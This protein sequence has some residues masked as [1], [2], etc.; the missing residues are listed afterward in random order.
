M[1]DAVKVHTRV[2]SQR[3][4]RAD[5]HQPWYTT[6]NTKATDI[7]TLVAQSQTSRHCMNSLALGQAAMR[8]FLGQIRQR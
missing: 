7:I 8:V 4:A 1:A 3:D 6:D 2:S 5:A